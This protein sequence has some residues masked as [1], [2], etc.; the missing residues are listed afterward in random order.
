MSALL[1][2]SSY[3]MKEHEQSKFD[4]RFGLE[5]QLWSI[6]CSEHSH[7]FI[8]TINVKDIEHES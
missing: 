6:K 5:T 1:Q 4:V 2:E 8:L 3:D 7:G